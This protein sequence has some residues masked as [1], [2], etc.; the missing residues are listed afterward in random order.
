MNVE[1]YYIEQNETDIE[2]TY[3]VIPFIWSARKGN[4]NLLWKKYQQWLPGSKAEG[5]YW[6]KRDTGKFLVMEMFY[7]LRELWVTQV[8][9][10]ITARQLMFVPSTA[11][12]FY[13][14]KR[15]F[16]IG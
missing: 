6:L 13:L 4:I 3:C 16:K 2:S 8:Y 7:N 12:K 11:C 15:K 9:P 5:N 1:K 14:Q 10:L